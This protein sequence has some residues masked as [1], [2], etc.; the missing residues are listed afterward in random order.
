MITLI[1][2]YVGIFSVAIYLLSFS[3]TVNISK[4]DDIAGKD[5]NMRNWKGTY[6]S[7]NVVLI[8]SNHATG[9]LDEHDSPKEIVLGE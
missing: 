3:M 6:I 8:T 9:N 5:W 7:P 1:K 2:K 4:V